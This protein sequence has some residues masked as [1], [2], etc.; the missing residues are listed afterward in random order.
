MET[1]HVKREMSIT[2]VDFLR[3]FPEAM[4]DMPYDIAGKRITAHDGGKR[5]E[6]NLSSEFE[7]DVGSLELPLT[8][9]DLGF[10]GFSEPEINAFFVNWDH[11]FQRSGGA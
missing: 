10:S 9:I 11:H 7:Q 8:F 3:T 2:H 5:L 1:T 6:I 4:S